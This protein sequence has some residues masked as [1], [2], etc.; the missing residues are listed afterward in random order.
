MD[1]LYHID[2]AFPLVETLY[3]MQPS[4]SNFEEIA[5]NAWEQIGNKHTRLYRFVSGTENGELTLP[6]NVV[7]I[8]SVHI[9]VEDAPLTSNVEDYGNT[10]A[11]FV[12][13]YIEG[14]KFYRSPFNERGKLVRYKEGGDTLY[15][16]RDY[17][18]V[19]VIYHG[20]I[21]DDET[22]LPLI[23]ARE[24]RAIAAYAAYIQLYKESLIKRDKNTF[25]M[26]QS[27]K[28]E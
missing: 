9:P 19:I 5:M 28:E 17:H 18:R 6:C 11:M 13:R 2:S 25:Q 22:G 16:D 20:I 21:A 24:M 1:K 26:A 10:E 23:N 7:D 12:E 8:E 14:G 27:L 4:P 15:F 3:G